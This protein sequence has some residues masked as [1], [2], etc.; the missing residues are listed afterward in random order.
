MLEK[1]E[2]SEYVDLNSLLVHL[3]DFMSDLS[4]STGE[5]EISLSDMLVGQDALNEESIRTL[6]K[7]DFIRQALEDT[8]ALAAVLANYPDVQKSELQQNAKLG[9]IRRMFEGEPVVSEQDTGGLDM[10]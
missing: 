9:S 4:Q 6:Q 10:F 2:E 5:V 1:V 8:S 3:A 7:L